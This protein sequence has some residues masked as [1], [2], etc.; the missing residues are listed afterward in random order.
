MP[1]VMNRNKIIYWLSVSRELVD[2][3]HFVIAGLSAAA[4]A[5]EANPQVLIYDYEK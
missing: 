1:E 2:S 5:N 3:H 4:D